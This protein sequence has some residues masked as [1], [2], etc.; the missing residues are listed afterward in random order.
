MFNRLFF[1]ITLC[2]ISAVPCRREK[3]NQRP[4]VQY[5][6]FP[7]PVLYS[8]SQP[9]KSLMAGAIRSPLLYADVEWRHIWKRGM[10]NE[11]R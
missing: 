6:I 4:C 7:A 8:T 11:T 9:I 5:G 10:S 2:V 1:F 3:Q